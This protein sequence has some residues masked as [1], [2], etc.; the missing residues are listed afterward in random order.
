MSMI[1]VVQFEGIYVTKKY[2]MRFVTLNIS[3]KIMYAIIH[4]LL[5]VVV[6]IV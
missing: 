4:T 6:L 1:N 3:I 2:Q 5:N